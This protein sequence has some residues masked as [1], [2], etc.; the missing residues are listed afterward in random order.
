MARIL[1]K[2]DLTPVT[3]LFVVEAPLIARNARPGQ[4]VMIRVNEQGERIPVTLTDFDDDS[5]TVTVVVQ[6]VGRTTRLFRML[7]E[8]DDI[9]DFVGPLGRPVELPSEGHVALVGGGFGAAAILSIA[10]ELTA[11]GVEVSSIVGARTEQ[12]VILD[13]EVSASSEQMHICTDDGSRGY[14]GF[15]TG[16]LLELI[17]GGVVFDEVV[18]IGPVA[19]MRA[20][21]ETTRPYAIRTQV[22]MDPIMVDGTG[23]CGAC[24]IDVGGEMKFACVDGPF[25]DAHEVNFA[26]A[27]VRSKMYVD[28]ERASM[29]AAS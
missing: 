19:M 12:L 28:E 6:E 21:A 29:A 15:V 18:A 20:V 13:E 4:F 26:E 23:M 11:R 2:R 16:K 1:Q 25:F 24:R 14:N 5:G 27:V 8:G 22:S 10:R 7:E 17:E 3:T 9:L